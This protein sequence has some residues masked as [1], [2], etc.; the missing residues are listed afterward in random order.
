MLAGVR[1]DY[2]SAEVAAA[3]AKGD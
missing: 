3:T 2:V 1:N